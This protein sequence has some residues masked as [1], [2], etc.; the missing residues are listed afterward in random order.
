MERDGVDDSELIF[1]ET[2]SPPTRRGYPVIAWLLILTMVTWVAT[3]QNGVRQ[4]QLPFGEQTSSAQDVILLLQSRY[5]VGAGNL[6]REMPVPQV[7]KNLD[8]LYQAAVELNRGTVEQRLRIAIVVGELVD[9]EKSLTLLN[10]LD[11]RLEINQVDLTEDQSRLKD[12]VERLMLDYADE[13][14]VA[15]AVTD[16]DRDFLVEKL[17]WFGKLAIAP[18]EGNNLNAREQVIA[19]ARRTMFAVLAALGFVG[20]LG[21]GGTVGLIVLGIFISKGEVR[22]AL[23][24]GSMS[25]G[26]IYAETF[27]V[28]L[29]AFYLNSV[30]AALISTDRNRLLMMSGGM[31]L[32]LVALIWPW[33]RG[34]PWA[35]IRGDIGWTMGKKPLWEPFLGTAAYAMTLPVMTIGLL[36]TLLLVIATGFVG[37]AVDSVNEFAPP[38]L[39]SHPIIEVIS[40]ADG[41]MQLQLFLVAAV[42]APIV[43]ETMFRGVLYRHLREASAR[44]GFLFSFLFSMIFNSFIFAVVHPQ[45]YI[46]VPVLMGIAA[47]LTM[48]REW[49]G[50]LIPSMIAHGIHN[51]LI[52]LVLV[53]ALGT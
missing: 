52:M 43:E 6:I 7:D 18:R 17:G 12:V 49:R 24:C 29:M 30:L 15:S 8:D 45:G 13:N 40:G 35:T 39:P 4:D 11:D 26:G 50:S 44:F 48:A 10:D 25:H 3:R 14:F 46:A 42:A 27:A 41:W 1:E 32:S 23:Q 9:A 53:L 38:D 34:I 5:L 31:F 51:G 21:L 20:L 37:G 47:G 28:W 22:S 19:V 36:F 16:E 2:D 33:V